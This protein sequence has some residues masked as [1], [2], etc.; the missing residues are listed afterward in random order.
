[1]LTST[2]HE[3]IARRLGAA[4]AGRRFFRHILRLTREEGG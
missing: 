1:M 3:R 4:V 2:S